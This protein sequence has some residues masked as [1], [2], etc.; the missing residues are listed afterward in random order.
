MQLIR[1]KSC[2]TGRPGCF[3]FDF[4]ASAFIAQK[5]NDQMLQIL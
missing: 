3:F 2:A 1:L 4:G 5:M